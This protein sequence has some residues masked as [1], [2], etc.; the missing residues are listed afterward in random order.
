MKPQAPSR[1]A[2]MAGVASGLVVALGL[3]AIG[4]GEVTIVVAAAVTYMVVS[5]AADTI[6]EGRPKKGASIEHV[7]DGK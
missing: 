4:Q 3:I 1:I 7:I 5:I 2:H 6:R